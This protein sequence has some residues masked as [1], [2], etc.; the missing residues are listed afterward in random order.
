MVFDISKFKKKNK[1]NQKQVLLILDNQL[2]TIIEEDGNIYQLSE[3][4]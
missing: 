2:N 3:S 4:V 1:K